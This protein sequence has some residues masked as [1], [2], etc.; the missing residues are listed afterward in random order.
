MFL[1]S[2]S[3]FSQEDD[4]GPNGGQ[5][6]SVGDFYSE[7][8]SNKDGSFHVYLLD[9]V[10]K[11]PTVRFSYVT[12]FFESAGGT[13]VEILCV[14]AKT[15]FDCYPRGWNLKKGKKLSLS[16]ARAN[17]AGKDV[18]YNLPIYNPKDLASVQGRIAYKLEMD[19]SQKYMSFRNGSRR[20]ET[21]SQLE[22]G[23]S[24]CVIENIKLQKL[25]IKAK[26][27]FSTKIEK[28]EFP[29]KAVQRYSV[30]SNKDYDLYC[31][32]TADKEFKPSL[33]IDKIND[34]LSGW[35]KLQ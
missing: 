8:I 35:L 5:L 33:A 32:F 25:A 29:N 16:L 21:A 14:A 2:F 26:K 28:I 7:V 34:H 19:K 18:V 20:Y 24:Y 9:K 12:G 1:S 30:I 15:Y 4:L 17:V 10:E 3:A 6:K 23:S 11:K 31:D 22:A 13:K 27:K